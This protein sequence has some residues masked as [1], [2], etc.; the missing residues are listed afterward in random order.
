MQALVYTSP[1][2]IA[3]SEVPAPQPRGEDDVV[4][5][6]EA[7][8][9]CG[10]DMHAYLGHDERRPPPLV[11]GHEAAGVV[12]SGGEEGARVT[13]N[14]LVTCGACTYCRSGRDNLCPER[15]IISMPPRPGAFAELVAIPARNILAIPHGLGFEA[16]AMTE[17][18]ACGWHA[19]KHAIGVLPAGLADARCLV[20]GGGAIGVAGALALLAHGAGD[21]SVAEPNARRRSVL[22][23]IGGF[24]LISSTETLAP[25]RTFEVVIDAYGGEASRAAASRLA[26]PGGVIVHIGL[27]SAQGGLDARRMTLQEIT[28]IGTYTYSMADFRDTLAA[29]AAG[30]LGALDWF[31]TRPLT[32]GPAVFRALH[33][34]EV[35]AP[36]L[37]LRPGG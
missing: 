1:Q 4:V 24:A 29:M 5:K 6:I 33:G 16:A 14:P 9:I 18:L 32:E 12:I 35:A 25:G 37:I 19:V 23:G 2:T 7:V 26:A 11:L 20:I 3:L 13:I 27:A 28:L 10:S 15:Q 34:G 30:R 36:K 22:A 8:G 31:E 21:V 17:P